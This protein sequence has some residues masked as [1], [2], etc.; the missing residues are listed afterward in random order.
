MVNPQSVSLLKEKLK[1]KD[2]ELRKVELDRGKSDQ[3]VKHVLKLAEEKI[4]EMKEVIRDQ[5]ELIKHKD[6]V[7]EQ[8][9]TEIAEKE[10]DGNASV[11]QEEAESREVIVQDPNLKREVDELQSKNKGLNN[12]IKTETKDRKK[13]ESSQA[14]AEETRD[15]ARKAIR[16]IKKQRRQAVNSLRNSIKWTSTAAMPLIVAIFGIGV[17]IRNKKL[18]S[19]KWTQ[20]Y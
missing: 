2:R 1:E 19:A 8:N 14:E 6:E 9:K 10:G 4:T 15:R 16:R 12:K 11:T 13:L 7:A 17:A 18:S 3:R 20:K 5:T